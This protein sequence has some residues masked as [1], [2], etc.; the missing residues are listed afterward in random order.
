M[1]EDLVNYLRDLANS[2]KAGSARYTM[3]YSDGST[4]TIIYKPYKPNDYGTKDKS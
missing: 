4:V 2:T 3:T 1:M